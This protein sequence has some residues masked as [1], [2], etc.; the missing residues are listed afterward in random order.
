[1]KFTHL[2][3][4]L[5]NT[6]YPADS[7]MNDAIQIRMLECV[8]NF[9]NLNSIE[10]AHLLKKERIVHYSTTLEWLRSEGLTDVEGFLAHVHPDDEADT[11]KPIAGLREYL[12]SLPLP[13][14]I[15]TNSPMEHARRVVEKLGISDLFMAITDIRDAGFKGKPYSNSYKA[16]LAKAG[17]SIGETLFLDDMRKYTDG[18]CALGG[19]SILIGD[20]NGKPLAADAKALERSGNGNYSQVKTGPTIKMQSIYELK[21]FLEKY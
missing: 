16:A 18:W 17:T 20:D 5:D 11:L 2:L 6:L 21:K 15:L 3:F 10:E 14:S 4:D 12:E 1:M 8:K 19:T 7:A 9:F 13:M